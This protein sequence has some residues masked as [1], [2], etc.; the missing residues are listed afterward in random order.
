MNIIFEVSRDK[1]IVSIARDITRQN[2]ICDAIDWYITESGVKDWLDSELHKENIEELEQKAGKLFDKHVRLLED[3]KERLEKHVKE[4]Q[5]YYNTLM[6]R[7]AKFFETYPLTD[8]FC[9]LILNK[10]H[11]ES[12][13]AYFNPNINRDEIA[14]LPRYL[15]DTSLDSETIPYDMEFVV[16]E[17]IHLY[18]RNM[19]KPWKVFQLY[20]RYNIDQS[21]ERVINEAII[22]ALVPGIVSPRSPILANDRVI[23][24]GIEEE[25]IPDKADRLLYE[26]V[27]SRKLAYRIINIT[28]RQLY[29]GLKRLF[30]RQ[31]T[32]F[33]S[34][35]IRAVVA[36][37]V[38]IRDQNKPQ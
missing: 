7:L 8:I 10:P 34:D 24:E 14:I 15:G 23:F 19:K 5:D 17:I 4:D 25:L 33:D 21:D 22:L 20:D 36:E 30:H 3:R 29:P 37:Y 27:V 26:K 12:H 35:Y 9:E 38:N 32:A 6:S 28:Q 18:Q 2:R 1:N 11:S 31:N 13:S 16:H